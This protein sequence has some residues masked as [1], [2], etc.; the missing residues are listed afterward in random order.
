M[1]DQRD[2]TWKLLTELGDTP[3]AVFLSLLEAGAR[4]KQGDGCDCPVFHYLKENGIPVH[5]VRGKS[6]LLDLGQDHH[7]ATTWAICEPRVGSPLRRYVRVNI[8]EQVNEVIIGFD[9]GKWPELRRE[10]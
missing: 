1:S 8:P 3:G 4:G 5:H 10:G 6:L 9:N 2:E 7:A